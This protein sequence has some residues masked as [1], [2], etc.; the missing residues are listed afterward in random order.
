MSNFKR[1]NSNGFRGQNRNRYQ[2]RGRF[3]NPG[4]DMNPLMFVRKA[5]N[6]VETSY[7]PVNSFT[8]FPIDETVRKNVLSR[9]Y[10]KPT[11]IQDQAILPMLKGRDLVG[12]ADTGT[13]KTAAFLLPLI[14]KVARDRNQKVLIVTPTRELAAQIQDEFKRFSAGMNMYSTLCIG[15]A[16][17]NVQFRELERRPNFVIGTPGRIMDLEN[18]RR[19]NLRQYQNVVLDE[20]DRMLDMGFINDIREIVSLLP[21]DRQSLFF[22][23]TL[24]DK[25]KAVMQS[26]LV[27][28]VMVQVKTGTT[29]QNVDQDIIRTRGRDK[30]EILHQL[31]I[32]QEFSKVLVFGRTKWGVNKLEINLVRRGFKIASIHGNKSQGQRTRALKQ[33]KNDEVQVL[34]ATDVASRGIDVQDITHVINYDVPE[35][36]DDYVHRIGR[37]GRAGK[38]GVALTFID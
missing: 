4:L 34:L 6:F 18:R 9:G 24:P 20:V 21:Q 1:G 36:Y 28:P 33:L 32:K 8:D 13:G 10:D 15:G 12:I 27:N 37:T 2:S 30:V 11:A 22:S 19:L 7:T 14:T 38:K 3:R 23:A 17:I 35:S 16:S 29:A 5:E 26:F 31:L 25:I